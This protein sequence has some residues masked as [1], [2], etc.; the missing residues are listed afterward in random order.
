MGMVF[1]Q[2]GRDVWMIKYYRDGRAIVESSRSEDK[3]DAK[4]LLRPRESDIDR[5]VPL[6]SKVGRLRFDEA[7]AD[8][9]NDY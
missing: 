9:E 2:S 4:K 8:L 3:T 7:V 6:S 1:K 5:G